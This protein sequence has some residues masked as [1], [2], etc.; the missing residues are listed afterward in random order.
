[1]ARRPELEFISLIQLTAQKQ[2]FQQR[3]CLPLRKKPSPECAP[4][5]VLVSLQKLANGALKKGPFSVS[6]TEFTPPSGDTHDFYSVAPYWW[7]VSKMIL[8]PDG[9]EKEEIWYERKDGKRVPDV[10]LLPNQGQLEQLAENVMYLALAFFFFEDVRYAHHATELLSCWFVE[11]TTTMNPNVNCGQAIRGTGPNA[12]SGR[13]AGILS[14]RAL[15]RIANVLPL[16]TSS[17][18]FDADIASALNAWYTEYVTW[19]VDSPLGSAGLKTTNNHRTWQLVQICTILW[20]LRRSDDVMNYLDQFFDSTWPN[21][22][23]PQGTGDQPQ[24]SCRTRPFHYL[25]FNVNAVIYLVELGAELKM[26]F[27]PSCDHGIKRAVD[28]VIK[29]W[30]EGVMN[31]GNKVK[32]EENADLTEAVGCI[33]AVWRKHG[34]RQNEY[35]SIVTEARVGSNG[36][37]ISGPK[38]DLRSLW[39]S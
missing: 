4:P 12:C 15:A 16:L 5:T 19:L 39:T 23:D 7:P 24:E 21:Q 28:F 30:T 9:I 32:K 11:P 18:S 22:L 14:T 10:G 6:F 31:G 25:V 3:G 38:Y 35:S 36:D 1:M 8:G 2:I 20:Y 27:W 13:K 29:L 33:L 17:D 34:D 26:D 37:K